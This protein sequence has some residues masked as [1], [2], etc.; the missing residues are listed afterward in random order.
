MSAAEHFQASVQMDTARIPETTT[1]KPLVNAVTTFPRRIV[2]Q[3]RAAHVAT[4]QKA[5]EVKINIVTPQPA[6]TRVSSETSKLPP[7]VNNKEVNVVRPVV[8]VEGQQAQKVDGSTMTL[9]KN[10]N[11]GGFIRSPNTAPGR[12]TQAC[13][14]HKRVA[15]QRTL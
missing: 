6:V 14:F 15:N 12:A 13:H 11:V 2:P 3:K 5:E 9:S 1:A 7:V 10:R 4:A 8:P